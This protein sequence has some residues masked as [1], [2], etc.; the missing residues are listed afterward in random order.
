MV[1]EKPRRNPPSASMIEARR[2]RQREIIE[3]VKAACVKQGGACEIGDGLVIVDTK[4]YEVKP[5]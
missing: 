2:V 4:L 3:V 1:I 5:R